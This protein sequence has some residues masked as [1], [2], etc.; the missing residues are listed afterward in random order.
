MKSKGFTLPDVLLVIAIA[1]LLFMLSAGIFQRVAGAHEINH[2][3]LTS[4]LAGIGADYRWGENSH[5]LIIINR[6][7]AEWGS[8]RDACFA[9]TA[10]DRTLSGMQLILQD[11][12]SG[13]AEI[14]WEDFG[15]TRIFTNLLSTDT[16]IC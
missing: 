14:W 1:A 15:D 11:G 13:T 8:V 16:A 4:Y 7:A 9:L 6:G 3:A 12:T 2:S 10:H 5:T